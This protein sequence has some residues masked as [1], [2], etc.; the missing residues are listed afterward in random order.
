M[1][2]MFSICAP[3]DFSAFAGQTR[4]DQHGGAAR[5]DEGAVSA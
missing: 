4:V 2:L 1:A 3:M 5:G